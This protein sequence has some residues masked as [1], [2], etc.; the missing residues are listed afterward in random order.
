VET[1]DAIG[2]SKMLGQISSKG[3]TGK[4]IQLVHAGQ[5]TN[6]HLQRLQD[7]MG[8]VNRIKLL[9]QHSDNKLVLQFPCILDF[10]DIFYRRLIA[11]YQ[12]STMCDLNNSALNCSGL[13]HYI[14][15]ESINCNCYVWPASYSA[16][17]CC[18]TIDEAKSCD[19]DMN[20]RYRIDTIK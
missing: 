4:F 1:P 13:L 5:F 16:P 8:H 6:T 3:K 7:V 17:K 18:K 14:F 11:N 19:V 9:T 15:R 20:K 10:E 2:I 12:P